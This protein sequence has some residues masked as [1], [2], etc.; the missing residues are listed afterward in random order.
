MRSTGSSDAAGGTVSTGR[1]TAS[2]SS[3]R[4]CLASRRPVVTSARAPACRRMCS[5]WRGRRVSLT[6]TPTAPA[7]TAGVGAGPRRRGDATRAD[8]AQHRT[9]ST[10][11]EPV[12]LHVAHGGVTAPVRSG[13][14][15]THHRNRSPARCR[16]RA[17]DRDHDAFAL[18]VLSSSE[19][20]VFNREWRQTMAYQAEI[21][22]KNPGCFLFLVDQSESMEDPF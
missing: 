20:A 13:I 9:T 1:V 2:D 19:R 11:Y 14:W 15:S 4:G 10:R 3:G 12:L 21:S 8:G 18:W 5:T 17:G 7:A 6:F 16:P 22:R